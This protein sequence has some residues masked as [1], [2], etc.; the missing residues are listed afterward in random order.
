LLIGR[1]IVPGAAG[2]RDDIVLRQQGGVA[3]SQDPS[4]FV[5]G[6]ISLVLSTTR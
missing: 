2:Y 3:V 5:R 4:V 1:F 6:M